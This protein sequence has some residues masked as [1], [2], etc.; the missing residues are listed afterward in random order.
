MQDISFIY[1]P[2]FWIL[3]YILGILITFIWAY[4]KC[5]GLKYS[6]ICAMFWPLMA[7]LLPVFLCAI[8]IIGIFSLIILYIKRHY[9]A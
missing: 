4:S 9:N 1:T 2:T 8:I 5:I 7:L 6:L 3:F